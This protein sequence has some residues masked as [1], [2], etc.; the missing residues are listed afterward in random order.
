MK[1]AFTVFL[2][3][4]FLLAQTFSVEAII[5]INH[6]VT[7]EAFDQTYSYYEHQFKNLHRRNR[8]AGTWLRLLYTLTIPD[9]IA[10]VSFSI[11]KG[12][13]VVQIYDGKVTGTDTISG[14]EAVQNPAGGITFYFQLKHLQNRNPDWYDVREDSSQ[15]RYF[16]YVI[17]SNR[18]NILSTA[19][20]R[21]KAKQ[22]PKS[23]IAYLSDKKNEQSVKGLLKP[24][25]RRLVKQEKAS[26]ADFLEPDTLN[27]LLTKT[28]ILTLVSCFFDGDSKV[29][30]VFEAHTKKNMSRESSFWDFSFIIV[31]T[32]NSPLLIRYSSFE[33]A[34]EVDGVSYILFRDHWPETGMR[35]R[36]LY[37]WDEDLSQIKRKFS[38]STWSD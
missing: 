4:M 14:F 38:D 15:E 28:H 8:N 36:T 17:Y 1:T 5:N 10:Q 29:D 11:E 13:H 6:A 24:Q 12:D 31:S 16:F 20:D 9:S 25:V 34:M 35:G 33:M 7:Q 23:V 19:D 18:V 21:A 2:V 37:Y 30:H 27:E 26:F 32:S 3:P 22:V